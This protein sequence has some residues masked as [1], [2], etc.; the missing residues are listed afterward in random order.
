M[1]LLCYAS[2]TIGSW[3]VG[4][5]RAVQTLSL[6]LLFQFLNVECDLESARLSV[7]SE[8]LASLDLMSFPHPVF[9]AYY[10]SVFQYYSA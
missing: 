9:A 5:S 8:R 3:T 6:S 2:A 10:L 1:S 4:S 7:L